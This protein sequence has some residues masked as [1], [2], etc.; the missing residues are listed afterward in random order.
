ME[1]RRDWELTPTLT[2]PLVF[3]RAKFMTGP[4][5]SHPAI[6]PHVQTAIFFTRSLTQYLGTLSML[7]STQKPFEKKLAE[8]ILSNLHHHRPNPRIIAYDLRRHPWSICV[9]FDFMY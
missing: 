4:R 9:T 6:L 3:T 7:A 2:E 5:V 8:M 1:E